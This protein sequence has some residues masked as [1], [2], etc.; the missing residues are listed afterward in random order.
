MQIKQLHPDQ[1]VT[2]NDYP[3]HNLQILKLY[4][5]IFWKGQGKI[6]PPFPAIH[7]SQVKLIRSGK[8]KKDIQFNALLIRFFVKHPKA[9][10]FL[11]DGTHKTTAAALCG[12][13]ITAMI[14]KTSADIKT[15]RKLV[16]KGEIIS[17][18][19]GG[20][21]SLAKAIDTL[22]QHFFKQMHFETVAEKTARMVK[23]KVIPQYMIDIYTKKRV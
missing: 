10:Y 1:I 22:R 7:K 12:K 17:L 23:N 9:E 16:E 13:K 15:A 14:F 20:T 18:T 4:H 6:V 2:L 19:T 11:V 3:V 21:N 8:I 5:R